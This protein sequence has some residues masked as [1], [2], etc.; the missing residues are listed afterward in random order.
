M[1]YKDFFFAW[2]AHGHTVFGVSHHVKDEDI[3]AFRVLHQEG[4]IPELTMQVRNPQVGFLSP[5]RNQWA[6][7]SGV[8]ENNSVEALFHG[9]IVGVPE[10]LIGELVQIKLLAI[11]EDYEQQRESVAA[12]LRQLPYFDKVFLNEDRYDDPDMVLEG[13]SALWHVGRVDRTVSISDILTGEDGAAVFDPDDHFYDGT[14]L[15]HNGEPLRE[16]QVEAEVTW[17][18][19]VKGDI[20]LKDKLDKAFK[21][22][23]SPGQ[24]ITSFTGQGLEKDWRLAGDPIGGGW[25]F[26]ESELTLLSELLPDD[27][28]DT[29]IAASNTAPPLGYFV[30]PGE[31]TPAE[32]TI[33]PIDRARFYK[34]TF[35]QDLN[36]HYEASRQYTE[37]ISLRLRGDVQD[38]LTTEDDPRVGTLKV[39]SGAVAADIDPEDDSASGGTQGGGGLPIGDIRRNSYFNTARGKQS[40]AFLLQCARSRLLFAARTGR[41]TFEV[42]FENATG[43]SCRLGAV[44][45]DVRLPGGSVAG[46]IVEYSFEMSEG[47]QMLGSVT[48]ASAIGKGNSLVP[49]GGTPT[50]VEEGY[51]DAGYQFYEGADVVP[52]AGDVSY[53]DYRFVPDDDG[54]NFLNL[55]A[56]D[57]VISLVVINGETAQRVILEQTYTDI[58]AAVNALNAA[59]TRYEL[60]LQPVAVGPFKTAYELEVSDLMIP[61][62]LDMEAA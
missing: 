19:V 12:G 38:L 24:V 60:D 1:K 13:R 42:P 23:G 61:R 31:E 35:R 55:K 9:R 59:F 52:A 15:S 2:V 45:N 14:S 27:Y 62:Q 5:G 32:D 4:G 33:N 20:S 48:V 7:F 51:V 16:M 44:V 8:L 53:K 47:G 22:A 54:L 49:I 37:T 36:V 18:Q 41:L 21:T 10:E 26:A 17:N 28:I 56:E 50:Y 46:K 57:V 3:V 25:T 40:V 34:W 29:R 39:Q 6:W 58:Q 43:L 30:T 11:P